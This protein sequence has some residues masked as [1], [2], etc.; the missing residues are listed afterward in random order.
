MAEV[1]RFEGRCFATRAAAEAARETRRARA[2][3][4][5]ADMLAGVPDDKRPAA[6]ARVLS[7]IRDVVRW[8][9]RSPGDDAGGVWQL[10]VDDCMCGPGCTC[11]PSVRGYFGDESTAL[12]AAADT[13]ESGDGWHVTYVKFE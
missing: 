1:F 13:D 8:P 5:Y 3:E 11:A 2:L 12:R 9:V 6:E 7:S 4:G 10:S